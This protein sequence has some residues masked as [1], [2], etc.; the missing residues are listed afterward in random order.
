MAYI[1]YP[2]VNPNCRFKSLK[3]VHNYID[4]CGLPWWH[5]HAPI[6]TFVVRECTVTGRITL[7]THFFPWQ[8]QNLALQ[9]K[10]PKRFVQN[11]YK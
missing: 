9:K 1:Y 4:T 3:E 10:Y 8:R 5:F 6:G 11:L 2:Y 7:Y